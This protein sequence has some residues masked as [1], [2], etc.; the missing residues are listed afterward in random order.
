MDVDPGRE[1]LLTDTSVVNDAGR[2]WD[3]CP[4]SAGGTGPSGTPMGVWTFG[5]LMTQMANQAATGIDPSDFAQNWVNSWASDQTINS[6]R[7]RARVR[8]NGLVSSTWPKLPNGKLDLSQAPFRLLAI[9]NRVDLRQNMVYGGGGTAGEGRFVF[10]W[11]DPSNC[12]FRLPFTVILEYGLPIRTCFA[13]HAYAH[14][15]ANLASIQLGAPSFNDALQ[16]ITDQFS[17]AGEDPAKPNGSALDQLR[18]NEFDLDAPWE[19][20]EFQIM[21]G[22][23]IQEAPVAQTPEV[24]FLATAT[25]TD[26]INANEAAILAGTNT[27]PLLLGST[28]FLGGSA[29]NNGTFWTG[30]PAAANNIARLDFSVSTCSGCHQGDTKLLNPF[31]HVAPR[32]PNSAAQLSG[33]LTGETVS[34]PVVSVQQNTFND[35][36]RREQDLDSLLNSSCFA[37]GFLQGLT[38]KPLN[39]PD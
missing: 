15:W 32:A 28:P 5:F 33:F 9:V 30:N 38:F 4:N 12:S 19:E 17:L 20:R 34:D 21:P 6:F 8:I 27:V 25:L 24:T 2:T 26:Y 3:P 23:Q 39:M 35:L 1:L 7:V 10:G 11:V 36:L 31:V 16:M 22:G 18:S 37:G 29:P 13:L 14:E